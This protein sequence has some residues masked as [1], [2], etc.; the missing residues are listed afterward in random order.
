MTADRQ[1]AAA[2]ASSSQS[3]TIHAPGT[4]PNTDP[5]EVRVTGAAPGA[6]VALEASLLDD[7]GDEFSSQATFTASEDGVVDL[8]EHA[9]DDGDWTGV[10]PMAWLWAMTGDGDAP[11][12][13]LSGSQRVD[14]TL[15]AETDDDEATRTVTRILHDDGIERR[16]VDADGVVGTLYLPADDGPHPGVLELHGSGGRRG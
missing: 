16:D 14:V 1:S 12:A 3:L 10:E 6:T 2:P 4:S 13:R 5:I 11:F 15:R 8:T 9:P 7:D